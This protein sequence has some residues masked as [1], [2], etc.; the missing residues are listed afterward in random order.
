MNVILDCKLPVIEIWWLSR[1]SNSILEVS[2]LK[3]KQEEG[4]V[5][6]NKKMESRQA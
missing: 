5:K 6:E 4:K 3:Q 1:E 2:E